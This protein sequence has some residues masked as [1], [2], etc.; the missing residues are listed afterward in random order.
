MSKKIITKIF[1]YA[2]HE[3]AS[4]LSLENRQQNISLDYFFP[5]GE[6]RSFTLPKK[7]EKELNNNLQQILNFAPDELVRKKYCKI[8]DPGY[9]LSFYL[10]ITPAKFGHRTIIKVVPKNK[11]LF[12]LNQLGLGRKQLKT[13]RER[14]IK[15]SGLIIVSSPDNQGKNTTFRA[16]LNEIDKPEISAYALGYKTEHEFANISHLAANKNNW[17]KVLK[18]DSDIIITPLDSSENW[19]QAIYAANT[20]RLVF[21]ILSANSAWEVLATIL[22]LDEKLSEKIKNL[23][24]IINQRLFPLKR[25]HDSKKSRLTSSKRETL[26]LFEFL[27]INDTLKK[28]LIARG[29]KKDKKNFW[30]DLAKLSLENNYHSLKADYQEKK[31]NGLII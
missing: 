17:D 27:E 3:E 10:T 24:L 22:K 1:K 7:L 15:K 18:L 2:A 6:N 19:S 13:I 30:H 9:S 29:K 4:G 16:L 21:G 14:L 8:T 26:A 11:K 28:W 23:S 5:T 31:K 12:R 20:K 25:P